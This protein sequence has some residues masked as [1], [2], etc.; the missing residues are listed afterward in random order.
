MSDA[1]VFFV[2]AGFDLWKIFCKTDH[3]AFASQYKSLYKAFLDERRKVFD[4]E[5]NACSVANRLPRVRTEGKPSRQPSR[6]ECGSE[7]G[8]STSSVGTVVQKKGA[9][10][11]S[12]GG[13]TKLLVDSKL[14]V[15]VASKKK[16]SSK[17]EDDPTVVH[18]L[19]K[20]SK[21]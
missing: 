11:S 7:V 1:G 2:T 12:K 13:T 10:F 19:K 3:D 4:A 21:N 18:N 17:K 9:S 16:K 15:D 14:V 8:S 6:S 5:Y 20:S